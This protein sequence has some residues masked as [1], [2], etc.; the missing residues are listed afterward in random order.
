MKIAILL[1]PNR[2]IL[3]TIFPKLFTVWTYIC[4][5]IQSVAAGCFVYG[6]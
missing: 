1:P 5:Y 6:I 2:R 4:F 3:F